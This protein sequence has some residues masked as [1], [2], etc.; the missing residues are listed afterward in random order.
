M[1]NETHNSETFSTPAKAARS[2]Y[3]NATKVEAGLREDANENLTADARKWPEGMDLCDIYPS[4]SRIVRKEKE[5]GTKLDLY[6]HAVNSD[7]G[8]RHTELIDNVE[9][10]LTQDGWVVSG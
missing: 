6:I 9:V 10:T 4:H 2:V 8:S 3:P 1:M 5:I 7:W